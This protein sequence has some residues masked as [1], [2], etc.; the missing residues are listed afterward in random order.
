MTDFPL[1]II[2]DIHGNSWALDA[3]LRDIEYKNIQ[4][5]VNLGDCLLGP[6]DPAGTADRLIDLNL[7]TIQ[8][9]DDRVLLAPP[10]RPSAATTYTLEHLKPAHLE[11]VRSFPATAVV[12]NEL[13]LFHGDLAADETYLLEEVTD[14][15]VFLRSTTDIATALAHID[16]PVILSGH[17][18]IPR[19]IFLPPGK[20]VINP[21]SVGMPAYT[22]GLPLPHGMET[23][24]PHARYAILHKVGSV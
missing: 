16:Q 15:G 12:A 17:S 9:N 18:H 5:I 8:G 23:G 1:A 21:G 10:E 24:S 6:L 4:Q 14:H 2:A 22:S 7:L 3:V 13:Y 20:L 11:W 19:T